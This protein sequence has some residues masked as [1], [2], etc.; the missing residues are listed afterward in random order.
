MVV[1]SQLCASWWWPLCC[2]SFAS[3][4]IR[5]AWRAETAALWA[6]GRRVHSPKR[7]ERDSNPPEKSGTTVQINERRETGGGRG[8]GRGWMRTLRVSALQEPRLAQKHGAPALLANRAGP[9]VKA[10]SSSGTPI[11]RSTARKSNSFGVQMRTAATASLV[12]CVCSPGWSSVAILVVAKSS[13]RWAL[14]GGC[15]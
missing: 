5:R 4:G 6:K 3:A 9:E 12:C 14:L 13:V 8:G 10:P 15:R 7:N 11:A 1:A 2:R